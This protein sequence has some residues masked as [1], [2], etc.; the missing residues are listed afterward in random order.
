MRFCLTLLLK[1]NVPNAIAVWGLGKA[2]GTASNQHGESIL[3]ICLSFLPL[4]Y[5][6]L[7]P[8]N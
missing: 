7:W 3:K 1:C 5:G 4:A 8:L 2:L 6:S